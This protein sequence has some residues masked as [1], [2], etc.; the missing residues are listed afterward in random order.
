MGVLADPE[1]WRVVRKLLA[2]AELRKRV[3]ELAAGYSDPAE[4][5]PPREA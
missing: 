5:E 3:T 2:H 1:L 4:P